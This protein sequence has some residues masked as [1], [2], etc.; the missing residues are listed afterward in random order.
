MEENRSDCRKILIAATDFK[1]GV[2]LDFPADQPGSMNYFESDPASGGSQTGFKWASF[3][4]VAMQYKF[5]VRDI[6]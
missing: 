6:Y 1:Y 3:W 4:Q 2:R 5:P